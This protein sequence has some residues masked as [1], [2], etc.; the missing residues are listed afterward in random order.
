MS[1]AGFAM[2]DKAWNNNGSHEYSES[3]GFSSRI[4][5]TSDAIYRIASL[6][7]TL[8]I[9]PSDAAQMLRF[10]INGDCR[11]KTYYHVRGEILRPW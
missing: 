4:R 8:W 1:K 10:G 5:I 9:V 2:N 11:G 6:C 7:V 3:C